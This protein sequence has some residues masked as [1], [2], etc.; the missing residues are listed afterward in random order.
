[1]KDHQKNCNQKQIII[2]DNEEP[3]EEVKGK[4]SY[5]HFSGE[6]SIGRKGFIP[7]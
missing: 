4:I 6:V 7:E 5:L 2:F 1:M 3:S